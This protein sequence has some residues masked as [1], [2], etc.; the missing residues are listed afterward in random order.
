LAALSHSDEI[1]LLFFGDAKRQVYESAKQSKDIY[2][3]SRLL[4]Q[5]RAPVHVFWAP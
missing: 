2:P 1:V 5:K 3:V 4:Q